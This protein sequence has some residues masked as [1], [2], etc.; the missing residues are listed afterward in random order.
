MSAGR[1]DQPAGKEKAVT[2]NVRRGG[3]FWCGKTGRRVHFF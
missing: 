2:K 3:H 1:D